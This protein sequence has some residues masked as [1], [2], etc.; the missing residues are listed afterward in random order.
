[1]TISRRRFISITAGLTGAAF[2]PGS[3]LAQA[4]T[5]RWSGIAMGARASLT[6]AGRSQ[7]EAKALIDAAVA[8][9]ARMECLFSLYR[10]DSAL[11][12]LNRDGQLDHPPGDVLRLIGQ[13]GTAHRLTNGHFDPTIQP[14]WAL[15]AE[16][17][18][19][20][21]SAALAAAYDRTGW[22]HL[23][24]SPERIA[25]ARHG[26]ALTLN[27]IAQGYATDRVADLLRAAGL[28][29]VLVNIGEIAALGERAPGEPWRIGIAEHGDG[30]PD[31]EITLTDKAIA[32][33]APLG[34]VF[35]TTGRTSHILPTRPSDVA[36]RKWRRIT[37]I[38]PSATI[39]DALSTGLCL[40]SEADVAQT[41]ATMPD[42]LVLTQKRQT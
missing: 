14:V 23:R 31:D 10:P 20:P 18:G 19:N 4:Q 15:M 34:T 40:M 28:E 17:A 26:M 25:F 11:S 22:R 1:M 29:N 32:T 30:T 16:T 21:D 13:C 41:V 27:G 7:A 3:L 35:D 6:I 2:M 24:Y 38:H 33:S 5:A 9:I 42:T 8:E 39:A 36:P 12:R 37:V